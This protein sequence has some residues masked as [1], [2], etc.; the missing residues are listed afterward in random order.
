MTSQRLR[1]GAA[2]LRI[3]RCSAAVAVC[4]S[5]ISCSGGGEGGLA[6]APPPP[7][8]SNVADIV[9]DAGPSNDSVNTLF[10]SVTVCVPGSTTNCQTIDHI[11]IDT[12]S[13]GLRI[14]APVLTLNLPV[15][16]A[17]GQGPDMARVVDMGGLSR[18]ALD[19]RP[20]LKDPAYWEKNFGPFLAWMRPAGETKSIPGFMTQQ[21]GR[22]HV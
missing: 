1:M 6:P 18:Y 17:S 21:I 15:Q 22:A 4:T 20:Y 19:M 9:V 7:T 5:A 3:L 8:T 2:L 12:A 16:L 10:T 11:Q 13:F 14:L